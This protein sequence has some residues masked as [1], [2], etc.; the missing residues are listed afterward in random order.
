MWKNETLFR[1]LLLP[2]WGLSA[3]CFIAGIISGHLLPAFLGMPFFLLL[4][5]LGH[6]LGHVLGCIL[7]R[8]RV[9]GLRVPLFTITGRTFSLNGNPFAKSYC[10][11]LTTDCDALVYLC[12][13]LASLA[14]ALFWG[15]CFLWQPRSYALGLCAAAALLHTLLNCIP[16]PNS[17]PVRVIKERKRRRSSV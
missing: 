2:L 5:I 13:P 17:D 6:E 8:N 16:S 15:G 4:L 11:F 12:G 7:N 14:A 10:A 1:I 3:G 9:T